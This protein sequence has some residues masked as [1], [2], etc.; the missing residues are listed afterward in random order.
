MIDNLTVYELFH[1]TNFFGVCETAADV[2]AKEAEISDFQLDVGVSVMIKFKYSNSATSPTLN[3]SG[4]GAIPICLTNPSET[5]VSW[6]EWDVIPFTYDGTYWQMTSNPGVKVTQIPTDTTNS[7]FEVLFSGTADNDE[8]IEEARKSKYLKF[9]PSEKTLYVNDGN[10]SQGTETVTD[11]FEDT[12]LVSYSMTA[13]VN[14]HNYYNAFWFRGIQSKTLLKYNPSIS[15]NVI[16]IRYK[17]ECINPPA[18]QTDYTKVCIGI[19]STSQDIADVNST[20]TDFIAKNIHQLEERNQVIEDVLRVNASSN[21]YLYVIA[22]NQSMFLEKLETVQYEGLLINRSYLTNNELGVIKTANNV[23]TSLKVKDN[24]VVLSGDT[25]N[26]THTSLKDAVATVG[27]TESLINERYELLFSGTAD[28]TSRVEGT[29]KSEGL[30]YNPYNR[31]MIIKD[32]YYS[33]DTKGYIVDIRPRIF[34]MVYKNDGSDTSYERQIYMGYADAGIRNPFISLIANDGTHSNEK[35]IN[36]TTNDI[37]LS[38]NGTYASDATWDGTNAS[39][40]TAISQK[41]SL[42]GGTVSGDITA[43][44]FTS[45]QINLSG[46]SADIELNNAT[47]DG[48]N[49]SLR[50]AI[51]QLYR[52]VTVT[53]STGTGE[54]SEYITSAT[55]SAAGITNLSQWTIV[56]LMYND[57]GYNDANHWDTPRVVNGSMNLTAMLD[58]T[59]NRIKI[60]YLGAN[61]SRTFRVTLVKT[62]L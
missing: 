17:I 48:V 58:Y 23:T 8:H 27:Q 7:D 40:K 15:N 26:G 3:I 14:W 1:N 49:N 43:V 46:V 19:K 24:D 25:W 12:S 50:H 55:L 39:L 30:T 20:D 59:N 22:N 4:S 47:W 9:N 36:I 28:N 52:T 57:P 60:D 53:F 2:V 16:E 54:I 33:T 62:T 45:G 18:E 21:Y 10:E 61:G 29:Q 38:A 34:N 13:D 5:S 31:N 6:E 51:N 56:G 41:L 35:S 32:N 42:N 37:T 11:L 44:S